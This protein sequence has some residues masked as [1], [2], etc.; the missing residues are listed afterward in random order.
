MSFDPSDAPNDTLCAHAPEIM[1]GLME[2]R[3]WRYD[4]QEMLIGLARDWTDRWWDR[5]LGPN[6]FVVE[7]DLAPA[8]GS[9]AGDI[10]RIIALTTVA[11]CMEREMHLKDRPIPDLMTACGPEGLVLANVHPEPLRD[12]MRA[13]RQSIVERMESLAKNLVAAAKRNLAKDAT[14]PWY[15]GSELVDLAVTLHRS[16]PETREIGTELIE[17]LTEID[18]LAVRRTLDELDN[19]F[20]MP[21]TMP[22]RRL[23]RGQRSERRRRRNRQ[24]N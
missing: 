11:W 22:R 1:L 23:A 21:P 18:A 24:S 6:A 2:L 4:G 14:R 5:P 9:D 7:S 12:A 3:G 8:R 13:Q 17:D 19:R 15:S 16:T 10:E 20:P